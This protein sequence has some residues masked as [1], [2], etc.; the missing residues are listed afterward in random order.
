MFILIY[1]HIT[2][3]PELTDLGA[4]DIAALPRCIANLPYVRHPS[5]VILVTLSLHIK[6]S[7]KPFLKPS[8]S[9]KP[10]LRQSRTNPS[11]RDGLIREE[12]G[13]I[14]L[15]SAPAEE[16]QVCQTPVGPDKSTSDEEDIGE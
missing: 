9:D 14:P 11:L 8:L 4:D 10:S 5:S 6:P 2:Q 15:G 16:K 3:T 13:L 7:L 1:I 12:S